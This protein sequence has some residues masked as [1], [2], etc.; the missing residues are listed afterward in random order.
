MFSLLQPRSLHIRP[1]LE[2]WFVSGQTLGFCEKNCK[3][4]SYGPQA[5]VD[6]F[7]VLSWCAGICCCDPIA[8]NQLA[9]FRRKPT[10][11][12]SS[13]PKETKKGL[14]IGAEGL[15]SRLKGTMASQGVRG[16]DF[17]LLK[18]IVLFPLLVLKEIY[19]YWK[20]CFSFSRG[21][22]QMEVDHWPE[23]KTEQGQGAGQAWALVSPIPPCPPDLSE[24]QLEAILGDTSTF[25]PGILPDNHQHPRGNSF[26]FFYLT[27][28]ENNGESTPRAIANCPGRF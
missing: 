14:S 7:S 4:R 5:S 27:M 21:L 28:V 6:P 25:F 11:H 8:G 24:R 16:V 13:P 18:N 20:I 19:R 1:L 3:H 17:H 26:F 10:D 15:G 12:L 23:I 2:V 22:N 9:P